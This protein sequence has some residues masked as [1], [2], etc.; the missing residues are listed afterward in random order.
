[1]PEYSGTGGSVNSDQ[2]QAEGREGGGTGMT[3]VPETDSD[4]DKIL[5]DLTSFV[6][7]PLAFVKYAFPWGDPDSELARCEG[8]EELFGDRER[9]LRFAQANA[10][11]CLGG[12]SAEVYFDKLVE[13][14]KAHAKMMRAKERG[15][16]LAAALRAL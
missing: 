14:E 4:E 10:H 11:L 9:M 15:R 1:M 2:P 7:D 6:A 5:E 8:P 13:A 12:L 16:L 3:K